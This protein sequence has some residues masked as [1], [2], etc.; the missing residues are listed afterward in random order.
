MASSKGEAFFCYGSEVSIVRFFF[1][2]I[3]RFRITLACRSTTFSVESILPIFR[4]VY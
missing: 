3:Y 4:G 1:N 2:L